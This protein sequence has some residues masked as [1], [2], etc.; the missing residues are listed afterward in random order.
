[1]FVKLTKGYHRGVLL[2][3]YCLIS[4][5]NSDLPAQ[6]EGVVVSQFADDRPIVIWK[7]HRN[8]KFATKKVQMALNSVAKW[9]RK[10][11]FKLSVPKTVGIIFTQKPKIKELNL[12]I[13]GNN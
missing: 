8:R 11:G 12:K 2:A 13:A 6:L 10:W 9:C 7:S 4:W 5:F 1:V 3:H